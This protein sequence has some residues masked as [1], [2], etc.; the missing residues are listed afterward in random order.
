LRQTIIRD[1]PSK[2][3]GKCFNIVNIFDSYVG[4]FGKKYSFALHL[5]KM[6]ADPDP[7]ALDDDQDPKK[8]VLTRPDSDPDLQN[9]IFSSKILGSLSTQK[10]NF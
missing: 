3:G 7:Q 10:L 8:M 1:S 6:N 5:V 4:I 9:Y 2:G